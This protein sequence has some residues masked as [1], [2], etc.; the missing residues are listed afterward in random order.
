MVAGYVM[1]VGCGRGGEA[2]HV[3]TLMKYSRV[4]PK[5][6]NKYEDRHT[7]QYRALF[8]TCHSVLSCAILI[9]YTTFC[10]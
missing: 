1:S 3:N 4:R 10:I 8:Q 7:V 6:I 5:Q 2:I 9:H